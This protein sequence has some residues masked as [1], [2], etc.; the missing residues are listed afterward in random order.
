[1]KGEFEKSHNELKSEEEKMSKKLVKV[2][3]TWQNSQELTS[4]AEADVLSA[5]GILEETLKTLADKEK[6]KADEKNGIEERLRAKSEAEV[7]F[8]RLQ[9]D[10]QNMSAGL[11]C[12]QGDEGMTLPDQIAKAH[13][14]SKSAE[15]KVEQSNMQIKHLTKEIKVR[16]VQSSG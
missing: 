12:S 6:E 11:V 3:S 15:A 5:K 1:M 13:S 7:E 9:D 2:T 8:A 10:F 16:Q 4:K 14:D